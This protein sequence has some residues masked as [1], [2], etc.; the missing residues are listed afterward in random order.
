MR[1]FAFVC[2]IAFGLAPSG[3]AAAA[4]INALISTT[5]KGIT[6]VAKEPDAA[7][8]LIRHLTTPDAL[9]LYKGKGLGL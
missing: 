5:I 1:A 9:A 4:E 8:A 6:T 2:L 7:R 3:R